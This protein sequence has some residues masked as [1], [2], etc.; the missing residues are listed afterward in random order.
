MKKIFSLS[1]TNRPVREKYQLNL[2]IPRHNQ[3]TSGRKALKFFDPKT[4]N[5]LPCHIKSAV[6]L[7]S[8]KIMIKFWNGE[9]CSRKI[10]YTYIHTYIHNK[11]IKTE[12]K[13][14]L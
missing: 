6:N 9:I 5:S 2:D 14:L 12:S 7:A 3:V 1:Q 11:V 8:F 4:W 13:N 10:C